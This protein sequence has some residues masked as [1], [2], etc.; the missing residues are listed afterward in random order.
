MIQFLLDGKL[1]SKEEYA[2]SSIDELYTEH[3]SFGHEISLLE[4]A[5]INYYNVGVFTYES[6]D[7]KSAVNYLQKSYKL[8]PSER[9]KYF[10]ILVLI[11]VVSSIESEQPESWKWM[12]MYYRM[13]PGADNLNEIMG[14]FQYLSR[15]FLEER[16]DTLMYTKMYHQFL[17]FSNDTLVLNEIRFFNYYQ[18]A[19][20][21]LLKNKVEPALDHAF[22]AYELKPKHVGVKAIVWSLLAE[23]IRTALEPENMNF[24][25]DTYCAKYPS[26]AESS[27]MISGYVLVYLY[28]SAELFESDRITTALSELKNAEELY[29]SRA[30]LDLPGE[31]IAY[32][33]GEA[34]RAYVR[35]NQYEKAREAV[36]RGLILDP[37]NKSLTRYLKHLDEGKYR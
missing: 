20:M 17:R 8:F 12:G 10:L 36:M 13:Q 11:E 22:K 18:R 37:K 21:F 28:K 15:L 1:I 32:V 4:L 33:Y 26:I 3:I 16:D 2:E 19:R 14:N 31:V 23:D 35:A 29:D 30:Q 25:L 24:V 34:W 9:T 7:P 5:G 6:G 27:A